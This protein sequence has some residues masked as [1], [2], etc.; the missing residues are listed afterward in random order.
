[1]RRA[2][3]AL[4]RSAPVAVARLAVVGLALLAATPAA[5][6]VGNSDILRGRVTGEAGEALEGVLVEI[7][8]VETGIQRRA[9]TD[10]QG[11]YMVIFTDGGGRYELRA[12]YLDRAPFETAI[13]RLAD[14][15]VLVRDIQLTTRPIVVE[16]VTADVRRA[17]PPGRGE[18]GQQARGLSSDL[19]QRLPLED[20]DVARL[21]QLAPGVVGVEGADSIMGVG[22]FS[23]AGQRGSQN[24]VTLDGASFASMLTGGGLG[25]AGLPQEG[26][27]GT[28]VVTNTYDVARGQFSGG[29]VAMT[30]RGGTNVV[31]GTFNYQFRDDLLQAGTGRS[32]WTDGFTQNRLSGGLGGPIVRNRLF[33]NLSFSVQDRS[34]ALFA[35]APRSAGGWTDLGVHPD[36]VARFLGILDQHYDIS[37]L[38]QTGGYTRANRAY[39]GLARMDFLATQRHTLSARA[40]GTS[41]DMERAFSRPLELLEHSGD[42]AASGGGV[43]ATATSRLGQSWI[44]ELRVSATRDNRDFTG[45]LDA[46]EGRVRI[47]ADDWVTEG[48]TGAPVGRAGVAGIASLAFGG[49]VLPPRSTSERTL[50]LANE[51]SWLVGSHRLK[52]GGL[53]NH[54]RF[55]EFATPNRY[56]TFT[57]QSLA[58]FEAGRPSSFT[59]SLAD[60]S[61]AG[62]GWNGALYLGDAWRPTSTFQLVYGARLET[63]GFGETPAPDA[64]IQEAF[65]VR[66]DVVPRELR[67]SPRA[68]FSW[69]LSE[70]GQPLR[71]LRGGV[72]EFRGRTPY[73]LY[74]GALDASGGAGEALLVCVGPGRVP[75]PDFTAYRADPAA[76][77]TACADG[78]PGTPR[79]ARRNVT[80]FADDFQAPRSWRASLGFQTQL[81]PLMNASIDASVA[82]GVSQYGVRDLNLGA[83]AFTLAAEGGRPVYAPAMAIDPATGALPLTA[84]R[85][86]PRWAHVFQVHSGLESRTGMVT[87]ALNGMLLPRRLSFQTS[88]T[89]AAS[90]DQSSFSFGGAQ[91]GFVTTP[92]AGDPNRLEWAPS[93]MDR[94]HNV[95]AI[96]GLPVRN[97]AELSL[98]GRLNSGAPFTPRVGGDVNGDGA[99][100]D[101]AFV[102]DPAAAADPALAAAMERLLAG[103]PGR[104][105]SCLEAQLG[106]LAERNSCRGD[107][108]H[109]LDFRVSATPSVGRLGRRLQIGAD[110]Y[111]LAAG[112]DLL[113]HG[114][115]GLR[116]WGQRGWQ[117]D[118]LLYPDG[119]DPAAQQFRYQVNQAFGQQ[120]AMTRAGRSPFGVQLS[121]R[122][123]VGPERGTP[124]GGFAPLAFGAGGGGGRI[125][126]TQGAG[127]G[128]GGGGMRIMQGGGQFDPATFMARLLPDPIAPILE[129]AD[130]LQLTEEQVARLR[131]LQTELAEQ[132]APMRKEL[133]DVLTG[134]FRGNPGQIF[135][136]LGPRMNEARQ[137]LQLG[138]DEAKEILT[139]EQWDQL[140]L[141][142]REQ[143]Q[144]GRF[145]VRMEGM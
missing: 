59:R 106:Q 32:A 46:P 93:N 135:E 34:E 61:V 53:L 115:G 67:P 133:Q 13:T 95:T 109:A 56:G 7:V 39:S 38:G 126:M 132:V 73:S 127:G 119:F 104:V 84:S 113:L 25:G 1:M 129:R 55:D 51:L 30:T 101:V 112:A 47:A 80:T 145:Q 23:V 116:G 105:R 58:D 141:P 92:T 78:S 12:S 91:Q 70:Q 125:T 117:D 63:S 81:R 5:A 144:R 118:V 40:F 83:P 136:Q 77:P 142:V 57:F 16:G 71:M 24:Q 66:T 96:L 97:V 98:V 36:S 69:R 140:P 62:S 18:A 54:T 75:V 90:R 143:L 31:Q 21:A 111:N 86:D 10:G 44:N 79:T 65:G 19:L 89:L 33:Y 74:A 110:V 130:T 94:R 121:A 107:W 15:D 85:L 43:V 100:N 72:G 2:F 103:A 68:G 138:L 27:R 122:M 35:L 134:G 120:R 28:Q 3:L 64:A 29:Q 124:L 42:V 48:G 11:R 37:P 123:T 17:P 20:W 60:R 87:L 114:Q 6:Q 45:Y 108:Q 14:E 82:R 4:R 52:L 88:Y 26:M 102:F 76:I 49:H 9:F 22:G 137:Q 50:E 131:T 99:R 128:G 139:A 8:S 41:F